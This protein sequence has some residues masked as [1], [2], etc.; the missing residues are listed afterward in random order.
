MAFSGG[1]DS[2][3]LLHALASIAG[4]FSLQISAVHVHHGLSPHADDWRDFCGQICE[5]FGLPLTVIPVEVDRQSG[6]GLEGAA[7]SAR[8]AAFE[9]VHAP[10][11]ALAHHLDD[12]AETVLHQMLR[13]TGLKGLAGMGE[14]RALKPG[15]TLIRPLL[16]VPRQAIDD[17]AHAHGLRWV[18]DE[19]NADTAY[20]RNHLRHAVLPVLEQ[21]FPHVR[22]SLARVGRH[23]AE[24]DEMLEALAKIDLAWDGTQAFASALDRLP[25][26]RQINALYY[27]LRWV[28]APQPSRTQLESWAKQLFRVSPTDKP[29]LAGG[30]AHTIRRQGDRLIFVRI[31]A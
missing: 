22:E 19:S 27:W 16:G 18:E 10:F 17:Y 9:R 29:H 13:G 30:H 3:V 1:V 21:R 15:T 7:R 14:T 12:Q 26:A 11:L 20:T 8:Y 2:V 24:A 6:V 31:G 5:S 23:A 28:D 4:D 25:M